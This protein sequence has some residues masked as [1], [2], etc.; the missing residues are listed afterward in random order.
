MNELVLSARFLVL[1]T[2]YSE[3]WEWKAVS[4]LVQVT[5]VVL[6]TSLQVY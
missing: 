2:F 4:I 3:L 6:L 5:F 1:F